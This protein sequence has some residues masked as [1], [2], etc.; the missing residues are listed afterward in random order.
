MKARVENGHL[1][2]DEP[3]GLPNGELVDVV[4]FADVLL[5]GGDHLDD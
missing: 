1:E 4:L 3:P 2:L 5:S